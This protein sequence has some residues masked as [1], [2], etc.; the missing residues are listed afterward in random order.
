MKGDMMD[1]EEPILK[2]PLGYGSSTVVYAASLKGEEVAIKQAQKRLGD[3]SDM[4]NPFRYEWEVL[5]RVAGSP[6]VVHGISC[7]MTHRHYYLVLQRYG[8][9]LD[10][11]G[12]ELRASN[13]PTPE[14]FGLALQAIRSMY[15]GIKSLHQCNLVIRDIST[16]NFLQ[17]PEDP[18][19]FCLCDLASSVWFFE[20]ERYK[21]TKVTPRYSSHRIVIGQTIA[22]EDDLEALG[23]VIIDFLTDRL[24]WR[25]CKN[26]RLI[27]ELK[28][29]CLQSPGRYYSSLPPFLYNLITP[30]S[31]SLSLDSLVMTLSVTDLETLYNSFP[32]LSSDFTEFDGLF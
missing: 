25:R 17:H 27:Q 9:T 13:P 32:D 22:F 19:R 7:Y 14:A 12:Q 23:Y 26:P 1:W 10:A 24:P 30:S 21:D 16:R 11:F 29:R 31:P 4:E 28:T 18:G 2:Q 20:G 6:W 5:Q 15:M 8:R 3:D